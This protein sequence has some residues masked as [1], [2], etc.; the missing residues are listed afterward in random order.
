MILYAVNKHNS[1]RVCG[2]LL[3]FSGFQRRISSLSPAFDTTG[4]LTKSSRLV[5]VADICCP[6]PFAPMLLRASVPFLRILWR[7]FIWLERRPCRFLPILASPYSSIYDLF[8]G[9]FRL[10]VYVCPFIKLRMTA[11]S[12]PVLLIS[13]SDLHLLPKSNINF[14]V[15]CVYVRLC[16]GLLSCTGNNNITAQSDAVGPINRRYSSRSWSLHSE[17]C[18][19]MCLCVCSITN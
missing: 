5:H 2:H 8:S 4:R 12:D 1:F 7:I 11:Q 18:V 19:F 17:A 9:S 13:L 15:L 10:Y 16:V 6:N 14:T 3:A